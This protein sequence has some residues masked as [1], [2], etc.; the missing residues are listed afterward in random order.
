MRK[1]NKTEGRRL[2]MVAADNAA[3]QIFGYFIE[4]FGECVRKREAADL[5]ELLL[6]GGPDAKRFDAGAGGKT[7]SFGRTAL[8]ARDCVV[9]LD[10]EAGVVALPA[11]DV[12]AG[13]ERDIANCD[14]RLDEEV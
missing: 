3:V 5:N 10:G 14:G 7:V 13:G 1:G 9:E 8:C 4:S 2:I 11:E 6:R 12:G